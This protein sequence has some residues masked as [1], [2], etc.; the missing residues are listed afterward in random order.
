MAT[1]L[2]IDDNEDLR[3]TL[4]AVLEDE[5]YTT[6]I[7]VDGASGVRVFKE[8]RPDLVITDLV[9]PKSN[10]LDTIRGIKEIDPSARIIAMSGGS[11]ISQD[12]Y[13]DVAATLGAMQVLPK[14]FEVEDLIRAVSECLSAPPAAPAT[15]G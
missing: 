5:G 11:L 13:L 1:V 12:Y 6:L 7:A 2:V 9:M 15:S 8:S 14:P 4:V 10:G 3:D